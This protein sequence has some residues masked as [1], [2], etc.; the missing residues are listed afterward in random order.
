MS[1]GHFA[2]VDDYG[3]VALPLRE[4]QHP[5]KRFLMLL[6]VEIL[7]APGVSFIS[8]TG[9]LGEI[10]PGLSE[11]QNVIRHLRFP[12]IEYSRQPAKFP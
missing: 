12:P 8:L 5:I 4:F 11:N 10:S 1:D 2:P 6:D 3:H 7:D 9:R